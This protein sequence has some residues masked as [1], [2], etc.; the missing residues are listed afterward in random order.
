MIFRVLTVETLFFY[1]MVFIL[2]LIFVFMVLFFFINSKEESEV[3]FSENI[4]EETKTENEL[5]VSKTNLDFETL[6]LPDEIYVH[7]KKIKT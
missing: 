2:A 5:I 1:V 4:K 6:L 7:V 3:N